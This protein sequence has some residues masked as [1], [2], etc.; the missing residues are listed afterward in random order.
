[1][2]FPLRAI[3]SV[4]D[5]TGLAPFVQ[6]LAQAGVEIFS[7]GGTKNSLE[8]AAVPVRSISDITGFPE[9]L[10]GRV[11]TLHPK[12]H[13]GILALRSDPEHMRVLTEHGI[14]PVDIVVA[15]LYP[16]VQ[17]VN[18]AGITLKEAVENI[19][20]GGPS[21]IRSAAKNCVSVV[22]VVDAAD[23]DRVLE[24][25]R[26]G[27]VSL[28]DR[29]AL[30]QK[31]FQHTALYD[32]AIATYLRG[33]DDPLTKEFTI[34]LTQVQGMKYGE[35]PH[36][37]SAFYREV[38]APKGGMAFATQLHGPELS[39]NNFLDADAAWSAVNDFPEQSVAIIKHTN[40]CGLATHA[41]LAEA[42]RRAL[43][44]DPVSAYGGIAAFNRKVTNAAMDDITKT[45]Y[46]IILAPNFDPAALERMKRKKN[47]HVLQVPPRPEG[48]VP[49]DYRR[50]TG[51]MLV[52]TTD[53]LAENPTSW[54]TVTQR[55]PTEAALAD[56]AFAWR[57]VK[58]VKSNAI[59]LAKDRALTGI[60]AGQPNRVTSVHLAL[61]TSGANAKGTVLA[62]DA[63]FPFPD[64]VEMAAE[65]G[66]TAIAQPG[67]SI[68][69]DEVIAAANKAN[70]AM[71]FTGIR[72]FRH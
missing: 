60:G 34:G 42:Y 56:L 1:M 23:Y 40:P 2:E 64:G 17:T 50:V 66:I 35:N 21:L 54:K 72:H 45:H 71:V 25:V 57:V 9:I 63:F 41:D 51:G 62:S 38:L 14:Q 7:T 29:R 26:T 4:S 61:R 69:D 32:T 48:S 46:D 67:G 37:K 65:A 52:Q 70:I 55:G 44:G 11:K 30:A 39:H 33:A 49:L 58:H 13:G 24:Q 8:D 36:Q 28:E 3:V 68:R 15:N 6:G 53:I 27:G 16:F 19:D 31:A 18:K 47:L 20:I 59:V 12:V 22:V 10:D 43:A 5:K